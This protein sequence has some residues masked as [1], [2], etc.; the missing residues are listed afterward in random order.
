MAF[1]RKQLR[2]GV[3]HR[4]AV[5]EL[6]MPVLTEAEREVSR[7]A[8]LGVV[9]AGEDVWVFAYGSL[10]WNPAFRFIERRRGLIHGYHRSFCYW[11]RFARGTPETPGLAL[12]LNRGGS[13]TGVAYRIAAAD[14]ESETETVWAREMF[15]GVYCPRWVT[16]RS[17]DGPVNAIAFVVNREHEQF[18]GRL[19][20]DQV[21]ASIAAAHGK[22]GSCAEYLFSLAASLE[23]LGFEDRPLN[24][25]RGLV[26]RSLAESE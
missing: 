11:S 20:S 6:K 22:L 5:D 21:A 26:E 1:C 15:M 4:I 18:A 8:M 17:E 10:I 9:G 13:C 19:P 24:E 7:R 3:Y 2:D 12:A 14:V 23:D 25:L 16:V